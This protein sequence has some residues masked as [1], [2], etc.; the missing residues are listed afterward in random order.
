MRKL[1]LMVGLLCLPT[2]VLAAD[3][4]YKMDAHE[5]NWTVFHYDNVANHRV[6]FCFT[7]SND[8]TLGFKSNREGVGMQVWDQQG[9]Q[10]PNTDKEV[11]LTV[12]KQH[13]IFTMKVMDKNT[14]MNRVRQQDFTKLLQALS[15]GQVAIV[16]Y[17][18]S[19]ISI[20]DLSGLPNML[21]KFR[22]CTI[23]AGFPGYK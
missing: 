9:K 16:E 21:N 23:N 11:A 1:L 3:P 4:N 8:L 14:L 7:V 17:G 20:V 15:Y 5:K 2:A 6:D 12:G 19:P 13:F 22:Q 10:T 18:Q